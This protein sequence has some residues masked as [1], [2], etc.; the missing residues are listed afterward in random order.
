MIG[1]VE[2]FEA[3]LR[4]IGDEMGNGQVAGQRVMEAWENVA[5]VAT[6]KIV[7]DKKII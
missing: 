1:S 2:R 4:T 5:N 6:E 3:V 7:I